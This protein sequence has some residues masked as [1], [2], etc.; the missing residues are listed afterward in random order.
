MKST[1][2]RTRIRK[3]ED[4]ENVP[5]KTKAKSYQVL[6]DGI[7]IEKVETKNESKAISSQKHK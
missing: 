1:I 7:V 6:V 2:E 3:R 5:Q 4:R